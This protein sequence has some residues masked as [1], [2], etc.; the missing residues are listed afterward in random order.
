MKSIPTAAT[1]IIVCILSAAV[2]CSCDK[3]AEFAGVYRSSI[4]RLDYSQRITTLELRRDGSACL[5]Y[6]G[7]PSNGTYQF[8]GG[9]I[10]M[11]SAD[12]TGGI[13]RFR[14]EGSSLVEVGS[15]RRFEK[16]NQ[17]SQ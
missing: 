1:L 2:L 7:T 4:M 11:K 10:E 16:I 6:D 12:L 5:L 13:L 15:D 14:P 9:F 17:P 3:K 8:V